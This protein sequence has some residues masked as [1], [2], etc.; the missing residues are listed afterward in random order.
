MDYGYNEGPGFLFYLFYF[1]VFAFSI[2]CLWRVYVKAGKPGWAAIVPI[3]NIIVELQIIGR[4][5]WWLVLLLIPLVNIVIGIIIIFDLAKAFGKSTGFGFGLLFLS[6]IFMAILAFG[7]AKYI[8]PVA[9]VQPTVY[10]PPYT[11]PPAPP[12]P[13]AA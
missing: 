2:V 11:P 10:T 9:A 12:V 8:G 4:P 6:P 13:P 1:A 5:V 3:Y 7:D